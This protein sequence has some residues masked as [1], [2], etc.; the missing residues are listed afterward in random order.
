MAS[1]DVKD[2]FFMV[3]LCLDDQVHFAFT[4]E[5]QQYTFTRL[6]Q[7]YK[8][9]LAHHAL[10]QELEQIHLEEEVKI[11]QYTDD[12]FI[13]GDQL[14]AVKTTRDRI[15]KHLEGLGLTVPPDKIQSLAAEVKFLVKSGGR[16]AWPTFHRTPS[17]P[18]TNLKCQKTK[19]NYSMLLNFW[20]FGEHTSP[21][22]LLLPYCGRECH[23]NVLQFMKKL[24]SFQFLKL[25][26]TSPWVLSI[27]LTSVQI[28]WG[29]FSVRIGHTSLAKGSRGSY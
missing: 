16:A 4:W 7:G 1:I 13:G 18:W 22:F 28:E 20:Y 9:S 21:I 24:C 12:T 29:F 11:Y 14:I 8:H 10:V 6:P 19:R 25:S 23:G 5:G 3:P 17:Q 27:P 2:M 26:P 15:I